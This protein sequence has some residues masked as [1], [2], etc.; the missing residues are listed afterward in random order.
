MQ[1]YDEESL[2]EDTRVNFNR[3]YRQ[4][5]IS[6]MDTIADPS[7][8]FDENGV[9]NYYYQYVEA[10]KMGVYCGDSG[11]NKFQDLIQL[12]KQNGK[13][14]PYDSILGISG[15]VDS[16]YLA[17]LAKQ[18]GLRPLVV[19]FDNG[20]N[21]ELAVKNIESVVKF[22]GLDLYTYVIDWSEF[23]EVQRAYFKASVIDIEVPTDQFIFGALIRLA[24]KYKLKYILSGANLRTEFVLPKSFFNERKFDSVNLLDIVKKHGNIRGLKRLPVITFR[25]QLINYL[26]GRIEIVSPLNYVE[27]N[28]FDVKK[29]L[30]EKLGWRDYGGKH[31]ESVF[32]RFYQ[33][34]VLPVKF[35]VDKRKCHLSNLI[36]SGQLTK[37]DAL[38]ELKRPTYDIDLQKQDFEYVAKKLGFSIAEFEEIL[39]QPIRSHKEYDSDLR[40]WNRYRTLTGWAKPI[41]RFLRLKK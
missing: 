31:Y 13:G 23:K 35:H 20:W 41:A 26:T 21:S 22:C 6:V 4:C 28:K 29:L 12:I 27:Y 39:R 9:C 11:R 36:F 30:I 32:T 7:I 8:S 33:G 38:E 2:K 14:K 34:Y 10:A 15:G 25:E 37:S 18:E 24:K 3:P 1:F 17:Y 19:H 5:T 16:S 40:Y